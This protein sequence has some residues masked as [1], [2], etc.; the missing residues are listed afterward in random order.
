[1]CLILIPGGDTDRERKSKDLCFSLIHYFIF[2]KM[3]PSLNFVRI[4]LHL[5]L[6]LTSTDSRQNTTSR[7]PASSYIV[8]K[9]FSTLSHQECRLKTD[10]QKEQEVHSLSDWIGRFIFFP[11]RRK[12][13]TTTS[14]YLLRDCLQRWRFRKS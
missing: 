6:S 2:S 4:H 10:R 14:L 9:A 11:D 8:L 1:M 13:S 12:L 3:H 5:H 7:T